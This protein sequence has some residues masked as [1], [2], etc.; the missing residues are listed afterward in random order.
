MNEEVA[1]IEKVLQQFAS[2]FDLKIPEHLR[3]AT[4]YVFEKVISELTSLLRREEER[5]CA[6]S[7]LSLLIH[8][9]C[10]VKCRGVDGVLAELS[11]KKICKSIY[12]PLARSL[13]EQL[14]L[15]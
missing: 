6:I 8:F 12:E 14:K 5:S 15:V 10:R 13:R 7:L 11:N 9:Y 4:L 2:R 1:A 3:A